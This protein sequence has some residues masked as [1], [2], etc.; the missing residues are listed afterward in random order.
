MIQINWYVCVYKIS[1]LRNLIHGR[2]HQKVKLVA[3][4][5]ERF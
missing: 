4:R 5:F 3:G 1:L 2:N